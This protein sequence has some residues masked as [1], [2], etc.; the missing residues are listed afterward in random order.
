VKGDYFETGKLLVQA[1][2][3]G[4]EDEHRGSRFAGTEKNILNRRI[5]S[6][7][8]R[9]RMLLR[10]FHFAKQKIRADFSSARITGVALVIAIAGS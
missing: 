2:S 6:R 10:A 5:S 8:G 1:P 7:A 4:R 3:Q 9:K